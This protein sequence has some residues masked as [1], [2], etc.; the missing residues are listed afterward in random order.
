MK[1]D[2][3][4]LL[5]YKLLKRAESGKLPVRQAAAF[6][7]AAVAIELEIMCPIR[8]QNLSEINI[9]TDFVRSRF[10]KN[11]AVHLFIPGKRTKNGEDIELELPRQSMG[12]VDL[13][14]AKYRNELIDPRHRGNI[15]RFLFPKSDG[16][17]KSG[18]ILADAICRVLMREIGTKFNFHLFRHLGCFLYL[19]SHPG[20]IDVIRRVLGQIKETKGI[21]LAESRENRDC[22]WTGHQADLAFVHL[23]RA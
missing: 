17:A 2:D 18:R 22:K 23:A 19:R 14:I 20:Q 6:A 4:L 11:A 1:K 9:D 5:P 13:Y 3:L 8:L 15:P 10:G 12:L 16:T 21:R 7:R